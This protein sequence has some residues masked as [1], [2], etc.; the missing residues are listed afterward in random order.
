MPDKSITLTLFNGGIRNEENYLITD[1]GA[2]R[3]GKTKPKTID[4]VE[5]IRQNA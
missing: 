3:L 4:E 2:R 5:T 1:T